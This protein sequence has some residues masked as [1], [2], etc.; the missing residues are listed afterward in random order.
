ML[1]TCLLRLLT[2]WNINDIFSWSEVK[3]AQFVVL[4][5]GF[6]ALYMVAVIWTVIG[7]GFNVESLDLEVVRHTH[8]S[9]SIYFV[10]SVCLFF[11]GY[12]LKE[13]SPNTQCNFVFLC[14][15]VYSMG[16]VIALYYAG[17]FSIVG[18]V[19]MAG[20]SVVGLLLFN[21]R[22]VLISFFIAISASLVIF[23]M[24]VANIIPYAALVHSDSPLL[25]DYSWFLIVSALVTPQVISILYI[26][27]VSVKAWHLRESMVFHLSQ[28]D[29]LTQ[30][31]NRRV[32]IETL[33]QSI[34]L[35]KSSLHPLSLLLLDLDNF[36]G[37]N[38]EYGHQI[39]DKAIKIVAQ[40]MRESFRI[41]DCLARYGGEE[42]CIIL[43]NTKASIA[44]EKAE[45][46]RKKIDYQSIKEAPKL[47]L[48]ASIGLLTWI[49]KTNSNMNS[50]KLLEAVDKA[51]YQAKASGRNCIRIATLKPE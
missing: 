28:T 12:A 2:N 34:Q 39:G 13:T 32:F 20:G 43:N 33:N 5:S 23:A 30:L 40:L 37:I 17:V 24:S 3:R 27:F 15:T 47:N 48:S 29:E 38:D 10:I 9:A 35:A 7:L 31:S 36:K 42:F 44:L 25:I 50:D 11:W 49:P 16:N 1:K 26:A 6:L 22:P 14:L 21:W 19:A 45:I 8:I 18:G 41:E 46:L 4:F 51:L